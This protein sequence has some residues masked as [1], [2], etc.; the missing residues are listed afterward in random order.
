MAT[1]TR[2]TDS[3]PA[4][5]AVARAAPIRVTTIPASGIAM[6]EPT[7]TASK[8]RPSSD[9]VA[10]RASRICGMREAQLAKLNPLPMKAT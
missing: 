3:T 1:M 2:P 7:A 9:G 6:S 10:C 5:I 8:I 4:M